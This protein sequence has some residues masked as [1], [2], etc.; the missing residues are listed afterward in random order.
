MLPT[1]CRQR[2][3]S[4]DFE[5]EHIYVSVVKQQIKPEYLLYGLPHKIWLCAEICPHLPHTAHKSSNLI[6]ASGLLWSACTQ[7]EPVSANA[8]QKSQ[9]PPVS[10]A[11]LLSFTV[12]YLPGLMQVCAPSIIIKSFRVSSLSATLA[13]TE[14]CHDNSQQIFNVRCKLE[15]AAFLLMGANPIFKYDTKDL[16]F[17]SLGCRREENSYNDTHLYNHF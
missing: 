12:C 1:V 13:Q 11:W 15:S 14:E 7:S 9:T 3:S 4:L 5:T 6:W 16:F 8:L 2:G 17:S 10:I